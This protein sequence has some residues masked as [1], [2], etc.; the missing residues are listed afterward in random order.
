MESRLVPLPRYRLAIVLSHPVQYYS[1]WFRELER[2]LDLR[3]FYLWNPDTTG[4]HDRTFGKK[5]KWD[6][7]LLEGYPHE[8]I[9][10]VNRDPGTHHFSGLDNPSLPSRLLKWNP[11]AILIFGY[12]WKSHLRVLLSPS[13]RKIPILFRGDSHELDESKNFRTHLTAAARR[14]LFTRISGFLSVGSAHDTYLRRAGI[15]QKRIFRCP[16]AVDNSRFQ[17]ARLE[18]EDQA[19]IWKNELGIPPERSVALF[20]GKFEQKKRP[21]DLLNAFLSLDPDSCPNRPALLFV[22]N[23]ELES[24]LKEAAGN[25]LGRNIFFAP[26]QNQTLMPRTYAAG[27]FLILPSFGRGETWGLAVN[28]AMNLGRP[29]IVSTHVGCGPDLIQ[30]GFTG[31]RFEAGDITALATALSDAFSSPERTRQMG[32][33]AATRIGGFSYN[34]TTEG[35]L[36]C[37]SK[38]TTRLGP[39]THTNR[40]KNPGAGFPLV[41]VP[42]LFRKS[43]GVQRY[44]LRFIESLDRILGVRVTVISIN[45]RYEDF[46]QAF[47]EGR[48][49]MTCGESKGWRRKAALINS[50]RL[51]KQHSS[52]FSTH[53]NPSPL[54][55]CMKRFTG[56]PFLSV[57]HGIDAWRPSRHLKFGLRHSDLL[58]PVSH[59]TAK[60]LDN[61]LLNHLPPVKVLPNM[62]ES[63]TFHPG[64]LSIPW[65]RRLGL[66]KSD[67]L[68]LT[69][70]RLDSTERGK[71]Y[72]LVLEAMPELVRKNP[73]IHW[74]V[75]GCGNDLKRLQDKAANFDIHDHCHFLGFVEDEELP[76]LYR[77]ADLFILPSRKEGFGIVFLEAAASG[78]PVIAGNEDGA[79]DALAGGKLGSLISPDSSES[80]LTAIEKELKKP[81]LNRTA[82]HEECISLFGRDAFDKRLADILTDH[83]HF[84]APS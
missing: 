20:A 43:G 42:E 70:C 76:D 75:G 72:D 30:E 67:I 66:A 37:L 15:S 81:T 69:V 29:A 21:L 44:S 82:R 7:P 53:P 17:S 2:T 6:I 8:F 57:A 9:E 61:A 62:V 74:V 39:D 27:D 40:A 16:H 11:D 3:V 1:P 79:V 22:G 32:K 45:D 58:L 73:A 65:R 63:E 77:S 10:N 46:P 14:L 24:T 64:D 47:L 23:G 48:K 56:K 59:F 80:V 38:V 41:L 78:I 33:T 18:V 60:K 19:A 83:P 26:F 51:S 49:V 31:W 34:K 36:E 5:V 71:G 12:A 54:L 52:V 50:L 4:N 35:L 84:L 25:H 28:E 13:L 55:A 68:I